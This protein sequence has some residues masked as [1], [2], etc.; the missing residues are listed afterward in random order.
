M[1]LVVNSDLEESGGDETKKSEDQSDVDESGG[2]E[3]KESVDQTTESGS[4]ESGGDETNTYPLLCG[5]Q[6][7]QYEDSGE[8]ISKIRKQ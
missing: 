7:P 8:R 1:F 3:T 5:Y 2:D 4:D 6:G